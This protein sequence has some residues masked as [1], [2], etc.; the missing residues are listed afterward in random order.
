MYT[1][2]VIGLPGCEQCS[3]LLEKLEKEN[4][5]Y[6]LVDA[7]ANDSLCD[8]L[9]VL[10]KTTKYPIATFEV[11][12]KVYFI[13]MPTDYDRLGWITLDD[14]SIAA[15]VRSLDEV[16]DTIIKLINQL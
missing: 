7:T 11:P 14:T 15:G 9:E 5:E 8:M 10:L 3:V 13:C 1:L 2:R 4:I 16:F 12:D 6:G